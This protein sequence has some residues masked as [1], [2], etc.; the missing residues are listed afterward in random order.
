M[1]H[2]PPQPKAVNRPPIKTGCAGWSLPRAAWPAFAATGTHLQR[3]AGQLNATEI[4]SSFYRPHKHETYARWAA[5]VPEG[6][7]FSVKLPKAITHDKRLRDCADVLDAFVA[8]ASGLGDTWGCLLVQ[9]P[10]SLAFAGDDVSSFF[11]ALRERYGGAI[12]LEARHASWFT[13]AADAALQ[14]WHTGRVLADPMLFD[15]QD[16]AGT[17]NAPPNFI[18]VQAP[19]ADGGGLM[20]GRPGGDRGIAYL[21]LHGSPRVYYSAYQPPVLDGL[22]ARL[23]QAAAAGADV[24]CIFDNTAS[25]AAIDN[26]LYLKG[27]LGRAVR[28]RAA[29]ALQP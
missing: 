16:A 24:W 7:R 6:F 8:Q 15:L 28:P 13:P 10:P 3:Y 14:R 2:K 25:G 9:L 11:G 22:A 4:N 19:T 20:L 27:A 21:R 23:E 29:P 18:N 17:I 26:A 12:V 5:S 1:T